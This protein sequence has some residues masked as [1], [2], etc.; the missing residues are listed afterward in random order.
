MRQLRSLVVVIC[1]LRA[2]YRTWSEDLNRIIVSC[3]NN[4]SM[5]FFCQFSQYFSVLLFFMARRSF[6]N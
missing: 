2:M 5:S 4:G 3:K 1:A 6:G